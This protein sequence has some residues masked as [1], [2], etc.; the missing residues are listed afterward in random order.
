MIMASA[1][2]F[3][4][5]LR[6]TGALVVTLFLSVAL[7]QQ[8][9]EPTPDERLNGLTVILD[10]ISAALLR[11]R[12]SND[13]LK[14]LGAEAID[15]GAQAHAIAL[16]HDS[17]IDDLR[18]RLDQL[19]P[20]AE[21]PAAEIPAEGAPGNAASPAQGMSGG[22]ASPADPLSREI[23]QIQV[24]LR[25]KEA[26]V[27]RAR[28]IE[29]RARQQASQ[30]TG[31]LRDRFNQRIFSKTTSFLDPA[32]WIEAARELPASTESAGRVLSGFFERATSKGLISLLP[33]GMLL[34]A[35]AFVAVSQLRRRVIAL[36]AKLVGQSEPTDIGKAV[37]AILVAGFVT[38]IPPAAYWT[39][40][41]LARAIDAVPPLSTPLQLEL[42]A[43]ILVISAGFGFT[44]AILA[45]GRPDWRIA[46]IADTSAFHL[47]RRSLVLV[48]LLGLGFSL[49]GLTEQ[50]SF[51][52][53]V[54][55]A[56]TGLVSLFFA[57]TLILE[58]RWVRFMLAGQV[59]EA[60]GSAP[61]E[62]F[63]LARLGATL[64][65]LTGGVILVALIFGYLPF[66]WFLSKQVIWIAII[67]AALALIINLLDALGSTYCAP[68]SPNITRLA[69]LEGCQIAGRPC[70][71]TAHRRAMGRQ[72]GWARCKIPRRANRI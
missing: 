22:P 68:D 36:V 4:A 54:I 53:P 16:A 72:F 27:K 40:I 59:A 42:G 13:D 19:K 51:A 50:A 41:Y 70:R 17:I 67:L 62:Q 38:A 23:A 65:A 39:A 15:V 45:P 35:I 18:A 58:A 32:F 34:L 12:L 2:H 28:A 66:A 9:A 11:Q 61:G 26:I 71:A 64:V 7:A 1:I 46:K 33:L 14:R 63:R 3:P 57:V 10:G 55:L 44:R 56:T 8:N 31:I 5:I 49:E 43:A 21:A 60:G 24:E 20:D 52:A 25:A 47:S 6:L 69:R 37:T 30:I 29:T 48:L